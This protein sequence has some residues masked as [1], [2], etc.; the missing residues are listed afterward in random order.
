MES[1]ILQNHSNGTIPKKPTKERPGH[2]PKTKWKDE[3]VLEREGKG[4]SF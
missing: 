1:S 2:S 3:K 4:C